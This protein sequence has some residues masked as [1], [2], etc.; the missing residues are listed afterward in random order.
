MPPARPGRGVALV[1]YRGTGKSTVG[2]LLAG[3]MDRAF[4][5]VDLEIEARAGRS[6][7]RDLRRAGRAGLPRL[8]GTNAWPSCSSSFPT[9]V[10][11]TGGGAVLREQNRRRLREFGVVVWLTARPDELARRLEADDAAGWAG[12]R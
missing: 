3:R 9:A 12:P 6:I 4:V 7:E 10:V 2:R 8:G 5:D 11:A 1:G